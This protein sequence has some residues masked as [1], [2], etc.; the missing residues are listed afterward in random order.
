MPPDAQKRLV[1]HVTEVS[2]PGSRLAADHM[3]TW[4]PEHLDAG[5]AFVDGWR[6]Q[7][8]DVDLAFVDGWR[9]QGLDV[10]LAS[11]TYSG[12][13]RYVPDHLRAH[14]WEVAERD[15]VDMLTAMGLPELWRGDADDLKVVP[16]YVTA[17]RP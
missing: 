14:G 11:L 6:R 15:V 8:L 13:Y 16:R 5:R 10:D 12:E 9:R 1:N 2:A 4:T 17:R 3:P 7:G